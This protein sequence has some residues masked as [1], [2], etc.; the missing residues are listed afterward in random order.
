MKLYLASVSDVLARHEAFVSEER[1]IRAKRYRMLDDQKR[2]IAGGVL[3]RHFLGNTEIHDNGFGKPVA[4]GIGFNLSHS[5]EWI[6]LAINERP[7]G[8]DIEKLKFTQYKKMGKIVYTEQELRLIDRAAD[9][10][11]A[12][13]TLWTKKEALLKCIG[14]GFHRPAKSVDVSGDSFTDKAATYQMKTLRFADYLISACTT[15]SFDFALDF[16][17]LKTIG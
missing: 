7:V 10:M 4:D 9:K 17:D 8:C 12:F 1:R 13:F 6:L 11:D 3:L 5:G 2:C 16:V 15:G 14:E